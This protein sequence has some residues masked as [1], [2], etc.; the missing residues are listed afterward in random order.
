MVIQWLTTQVNRPFPSFKKSHFPSEAKCE[1]IDMK[2]S[3]N[4]DAN[5]TY[6]HNKGFA[7]SLVLKVRFFGTRKWP[8]MPRLYREKLSREW[9][10]VALP[11]D[12]TSASVYMRKSLTSLPE[13]RADNS[14]GECFDCL[15]LTEMTRRGEPNCLYQEKLSQLGW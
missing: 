12:S 3:F 8:I 4:Y 5:K 14:A 13:P 11:A 10:R 6:F 2:M 9:Q 1:A 15:A 7:L